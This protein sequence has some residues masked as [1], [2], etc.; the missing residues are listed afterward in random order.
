MLRVSTHIWSYFIYFFHISEFSA[1]KI[2]SCA[3]IDIFPLFFVFV[4]F[5]E[6][7]MRIISERTL[8]TTIYGIQQ[9]KYS[10]FRLFGAPFYL[11]KVL[12]KKKIIITLLLIIEAAALLGQITQNRCVPINYNLL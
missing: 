11:V 12:K 2:V 3:S 10:S 7:R 6:N 4:F 1:V 8:Y 9:Q 5:V